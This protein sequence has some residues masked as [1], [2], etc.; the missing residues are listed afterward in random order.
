MC[1]Y[2]YIYI[3]IFI[4]F[5]SSPSHS[6]AHAWFHNKYEYSNICCKSNKG[7]NF[8]LNVSWNFVYRKFLR[9]INMNLL[10]ILF[11][12]WEDLTFPIF[13]YY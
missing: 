4:L 13:D 5:N 7:A 6:R 2:I 8:E 11:M 1:V 3:Y 12:V 9:S 10:K